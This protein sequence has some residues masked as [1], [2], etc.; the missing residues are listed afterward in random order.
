MTMMLVLLI[1]LLV[2]ELITMTLMAGCAA[3]GLTVAIILK[4]LG[5][6]LW[7]QAAAGVIVTLALLIMVRPYLAR[8]LNKSTKQSKN[9]KLIGADAIVI[10][11]I[12][13]S[14]GV[15]VVNVSGKEWSARTKHP[16]RV[17]REGNVVTVV[18][19]NGDVAIVDDRVRRINR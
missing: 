13:N 8:H 9:M 4:V 12:D 7:I 16:N 1:V 2:V 5:Q 18:A 11:E 14:Q 3:V 19:M 10:C 15:G 6:P 17:I